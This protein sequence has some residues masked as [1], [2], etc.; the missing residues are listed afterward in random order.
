MFLYISIRLYD[1]VYIVQMGSALA[2]SATLKLKVCPV[3]T[4][5]LRLSDVCFEDGFSGSQKRNPEAQSPFCCQIYL[6]LSDMISILKTGSAAAKSATLR[7]K[8]RS[9]VTSLY[10]CLI[11]YLFRRRVERLIIN[12]YLEIHLSE[13]LRLFEP[14]RPEFMY[15]SYLLLYTPRLSG[16]WYLFLL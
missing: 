11:W 6:Q 8:V 5:L 2:K 16:L 15:I 1:V 7:L 9:V 13:V 4:S 14:R 3:V 10:G 12:R